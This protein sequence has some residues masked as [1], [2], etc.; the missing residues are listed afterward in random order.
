M[1]NSL[2]GLTHN[3]LVLR[4]KPNWA[5]NPK[6][7]IS[8]NRD[9][10]KLNESAVTLVNIS[11]YLY[12]EITYSYTF[13]TRGEVYDFVQWYNQRQGKLQRFWLPIVRNE[14]ELYSPVNQFDSS[15]IVVSTGFVEVYQGY[16]RIYLELS[17][18]DLITHKVTGVIDNG[19]GTETLQLD[20]LM[21]RNIALSE[22]NWFSR[23][24]LVRFN[25]DS[26][27]MTHSTDGVAEATVTYRELVREYETTG[28][29]S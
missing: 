2:N 19:D 25:R 29:G 3:E 13:A 22:V 4:K 12:H 15:L 1:S 10:I 8:M 21:D 20:A 24:M 5:E 17:N 23:I 9:L 11:D 27:Q 7:T 26:L 14:F 16:E 28:E 18:G 6:R